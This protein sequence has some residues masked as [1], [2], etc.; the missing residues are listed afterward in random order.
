MKIHHPE[1]AHTELRDGKK[2]TTYIDAW[3]EEVG[4]LN[5]PCCGKT[6]TFHI[7]KEQMAQGVL[8]NRFNLDCTSCHLGF[9]GL[10]DPHVFTDQEDFLVFVRDRLEEGK[11]NA[12]VH[13]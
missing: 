5:C 8:S 13:P 12:P 6:M 11:K 9:G 3:D 10:E 4:D 2:F 7:S 1:V